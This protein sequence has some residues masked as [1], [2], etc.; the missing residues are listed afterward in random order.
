MFGKVL[1]SLAII[2][3]FHCVSGN[4]LIFTPCAGGHPTPEWVE[5]DM[6]SGDLCSF[7]RGQYWVGKSH[8]I[9]RDVFHTLMVEISITFLGIPVNIDIP[10]PYNNSCNF[11]FPGQSCP[12][13]VNGEYTWDMLAPIDES[14]PS[15]VTV[16]MR[17]K[18]I[19]K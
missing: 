15:G 14:F 1:V 12:T 9:A 7:P 2:L 6:C 13:A 5:S 16:P 19:S 3:A 4:R 11:L 10:E 18:F 17:S 8:F